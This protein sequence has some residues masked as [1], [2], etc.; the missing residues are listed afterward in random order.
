MRNGLS[1]KPGGLWQLVCGGRH[2]TGSD[3]DANLGTALAD[4]P[5]EFETVCLSRHLDIRYHEFEGMITSRSVK[6]SSA[7]PASMTS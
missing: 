7:L 6:A 2:R 5:R 3:D 4:L 1:D